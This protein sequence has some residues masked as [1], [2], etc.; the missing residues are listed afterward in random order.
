MPV[1]NFVHY[2]SEWHNIMLSI[3]DKSV[4]LNTVFQKK[5]YHP[6]TNNNFNS[7]CLIPVIFGANIT[8]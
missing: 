1:I 8:E 3:C 7:S 5:G 4:N 2:S 6:T